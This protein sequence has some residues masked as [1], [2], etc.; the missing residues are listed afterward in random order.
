MD[1]LKRMTDIEEIRQLKARY[2]RFLDTKDWEGFESL[3]SVDAILDMRSGRGDN[4]DPDAVIQGASAIRAF[5][6]AA[7]QALVTV[8]HGHM[9]EIE[10]T[11]P[12]VARA[13][14]AME[15]VLYAPEDSEMPF[16]SLHGYGHYHETYEKLAGRW[17]IKSLKL[18]RLV[19]HTT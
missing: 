10:I 1:E 18:T 4:L 3:F 11:A 17:A 6:S 14:W 16:R 13:V 15:D 2:F 5:V 8:H 19:V 7:V 9:P 12:D